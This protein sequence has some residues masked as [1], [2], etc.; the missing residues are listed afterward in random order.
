MVVDNAPAFR[1]ALK[2]QG[3]D[4]AKL[5]LFALQTPVAQDQSGI[6]TQEAK[7]EVG[8]IERAHRAAIRVIFFVTREDG[9]PSPG[10]A[11]ASGKSEIGGMPIAGEKGVDV[12]AIPSFLLGGED[13]VNGGAISLSVSGFVSGS[14]GWR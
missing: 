7:F 10:D 4:S 12:A 2:D 3:E 8:K 1:E 9:A 13:G 14:N 5:I 11:V 6:R